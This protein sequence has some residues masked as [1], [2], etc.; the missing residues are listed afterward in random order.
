MP[1]R[2]AARSPDPPARPSPASALR[3]CCIV[4][5]AANAIAAAAA[6]GYPPTAKHSVSDAYHGVS[7][8]DD[9]RWLE[10]DASSDVKRWVTEQNSFTRHYLDAIPQRSAI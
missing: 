3:V 9:Y 6:P 1:M 5:G 4:L 8:T 7:V 10:E 2:A